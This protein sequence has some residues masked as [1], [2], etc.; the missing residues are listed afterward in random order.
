MYCIHL[1]ISAC[2]YGT[3]VAGTQVHLVACTCIDNHPLAVHGRQCPDVRSRFLALPGEGCTALYLRT[4]VVE[5]VLS[6]A[7]VN[8]RYY[9]IGIGLNTAF[10]LLA[11]GGN[12]TFR[13]KH[14]RP[15]KQA[16]CRQ[17]H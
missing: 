16:G 17:K 9:I 12:Q 5:I 15:G 14:F 8:T 13:S 7:L 4:V 10:H 1:F 6:A 3:A 2:S 11:L